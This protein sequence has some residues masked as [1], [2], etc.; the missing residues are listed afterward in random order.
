MRKNI[1][2][3]TYILILMAQTIDNHSLKFLIFWLLIYIYIF[4]KIYQR[5]YKLL[6]NNFPIK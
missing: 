6:Y 2:Y 3:N 1:K 5:A 4:Y